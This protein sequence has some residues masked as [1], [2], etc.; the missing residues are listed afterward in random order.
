MIKSPWEAALE[1]GSVESAFQVMGP[2]FP[3]RGYIV[4]PTSGALEALKDGGRSSRATVCS[5]PTRT[6]TPKSCQ[7]IYKPKIPRGWNTQCNR[8]QPPT[9]G[10]RITLII[11]NKHD[12]HYRVKH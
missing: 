6:I 8:Q 3:P 12:D 9:Y 10:T 7:D 4:A 11:C 1:T 2:V 5:T